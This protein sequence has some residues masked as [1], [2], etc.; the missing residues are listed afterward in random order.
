MDRLHHQARA[1]SPPSTVLSFYRAHG[2]LSDPGRHAPEIDALPDDVGA[3]A[4]VVRGLLIHGEWLHLYGL[5]P[6]DVPALSRETVP[7]ERR[8]DT[9]L[10]REGGSLSRSRPAALRAPV[11]CRDFALMLCAL[12]RQ[13]SIPARV[14]CGFAPYFERGRKEDHWVCEYWKAQE[15]RWTIA[16]A[17]LDEE[18]RAHLQIRFDT[19]DLPQDQFVFSGAAWQRCRS[20]IAAA[21][22]FGHGPSAGA[23]FLRVNVARDLL[24]LGKQEV[25]EWDAWRAAP[26]ESQGVDPAASAWCDEVAALLSDVDRH[27]SK[28]RSPPQSWEVQLRPFWKL[29]K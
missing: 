14:R 11:T 3:L 1:G 18:H 9:I 27:L 28:I 24:S 25:S 7:V 2:T 22:A 12:L 15:G 6:R 21:A 20:G 10:S 16:D 23:W 5:T 8:L 26:A 17:Q 13:K 19:L 29:P 4:G